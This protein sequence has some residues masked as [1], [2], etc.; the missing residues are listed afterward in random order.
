MSGRYCK[1][2]RS[3]TIRFK[4][5]YIVTFFCEVNDI[6]PI[7]VK[8]DLRLRIQMLEYVLLFIYTTYSFVF[9][10]SDNHA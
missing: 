3:R 9:N 2:I 8:E 1:T 10:N 7:R 5:L 4:H 6:G